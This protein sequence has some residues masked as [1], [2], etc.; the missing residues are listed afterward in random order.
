MDGN[1][2]SQKERDVPLVGGNNQEAFMQAL[3]DDAKQ[4][5][6]RRQE[7]LKLSNDL[8]EKGN[9]EYQKNNFAKS[10]EFYTEVSQRQ[11][12]LNRRKCNYLDLNFFERRF[13]KQKTTLLCIRIEPKHLLSWKNIKKRLKIVIG[14]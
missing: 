11:K 3:E 9:E 12:E 14:R 5:F 10:I 1:E 8:K 13:K 6:K 2:T 4:R 7:N